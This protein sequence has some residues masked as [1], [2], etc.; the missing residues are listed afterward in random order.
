MSSEK[1]KIA[2]VLT[3]LPIDNPFLVTKV[4]IQLSKS[5][6]ISSYEFI[7]ENPT[8]D[9]LR[10]TMLRLIDDGVKYFTGFLISITL[11]TVLDIIKSNPDITV[12]SLR[13]AVEEFETIDN[14]YRIL[15]PFTLSSTGVFNYLTKNQDIQKMITVTNPNNPIYVSGKN[16][17]EEAARTFGIEILPTVETATEL[18]E[19]LLKI[20][21]SEN[22]FILTFFFLDELVSF[23][24]DCNRI[25]EA[26]NFFFTNDNFIFMGP[27]ETF[28]I[29]DILFGNPDVRR[30]MND[31]KYKAFFYL[32][33]K[34]ETSSKLIPDDPALT[35]LYLFDSILLIDTAVRKNIGMLDASRLTRGLTGIMDLDRNGD[36]LNA[37]VG[38][39][40]ADGDKFSEQTTGI[41]Q[42]SLDNTTSE[43]LFFG[44]RYRQII[45]SQVM[46]TLHL[47]PTEI[48][49]FNATLIEKVSETEFLVERNLTGGQPERILIRQELGPNTLQSAPIGSDIELEGSPTG[50]FKDCPGGGDPFIKPIRQQNELQADF[51]VHASGFSGLGGGSAPF[52][53][54]TEDVTETSSH[55]EVTLKENPLEKLSRLS[56]QKTYAVLKGQT[57][58]RFEKTKS[59]KLPKDSDFF[60]WRTREINPKSKN[61]KIQPMTV[62]DQIYFKLL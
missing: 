23:L 3:T 28:A 48:L 54:P 50:C 47:E 18:L 57:T 42:T 59:G 36:R 62:K 53:A 25:D 38:I 40:Q 11:T 8:L 52:N 43:S 33:D 39:F 35:P 7:V 5:I 31:T 6:D 19:S 55:I 29:T 44:L 41:Y 17:F 1:T 22:V 2:I 12:I 49:K 4:L 34:S 58:M 27:D 9:E 61:V 14:I 15:I 16:T 46:S 30:F 45:D 21:D 32:A 60:T 13:S 10:E 24:E 20:P 51:V 37:L 26:T 56:E